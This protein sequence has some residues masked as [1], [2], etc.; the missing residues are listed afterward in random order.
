M[1]T[2]KAFELAQL[3]ALTSVDASGN[4]TTNTSQIAN[5]SGN[6]TI[7]SVA[8]IILNADGADIILADDAVDFGRFKRDAGDFVI[9][10]ETANKDLIFILFGPLPKY[11]YSNFYLA[12]TFEKMPK[13][14]HSR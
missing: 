10:S 8:D 14:N 13:A 9:K 11:V 6:L 2:T 7:D 4:V 12:D 3:S 5:A 1:A